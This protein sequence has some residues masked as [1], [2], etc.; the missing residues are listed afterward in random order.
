MFEFGYDVREGTKVGYD[1]STKATTRV[2]SF[3]L[4]AGGPAVGVAI[5]TTYFTVSTITVCIT[6]FSF[7]TKF[8]TIFSTGFY[9]TFSTMTVWIICLT[10]DP[11]SHATRSPEATAKVSTNVKFNKSWFIT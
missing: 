2:W 5:F 3:G 7:S 6:A 1:T 11:F 4:G 10:S 9:T 8:S